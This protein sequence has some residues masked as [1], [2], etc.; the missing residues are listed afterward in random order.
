M[1][2]LHH[3]RNLLPFPGIP[4]TDI[5]VMIMW[6]PC[7]V[8]FRAAPMRHQNS[9]VKNMYVIIGSSTPVTLGGKLHT[10]L[11]EIILLSYRSNLLDPQ[12]YFGGEEKRLGLKQIK[13]KKLNK[14]EMQSH[15][16]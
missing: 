12:T 16:K 5:L 2:K 15:T 3:D 7:G 9:Y 11:H 6:S 1:N 8:R 14:S 13:N 10:C 4:R